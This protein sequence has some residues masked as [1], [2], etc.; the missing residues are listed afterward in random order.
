MRAAYAPYTLNFITPGG[1]SRGVMTT[2]DTYFIKLWDESNPE[3]FGIGECALFKGLSIEDDANYEAKLQELCINI[4]NGEA[5]DLSDHS[6]ILFGFETAILD[7][8]NGGNRICYPT[9]FT[10]GNYH[11]LI[12]GL[13]WMGNKEDMIKR[14][15]EKVNAGFHTIKLKIGAID[16]AQELEMIEYVRTRY[17]EKDLE[18]RLD[19]NGGFSPENALQRIDALSKYKIHSIEQPI[20]AGLWEEMAEICNKSNI[21]IALDEELIGITNPM[22]MMEVLKNIRPHYIIL[23]PSLMGG[24]SGSLEWLKMAAQFQIGGWITSA[25]ESNIGLNALAQWVT[26][27]QPRIPQGLGSGGIF[28]NNISSPLYQ[29]KD[30]LGY[31]P[32][33]KWQIPELNWIST[34]NFK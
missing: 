18:I 14:I 25:L 12:N 17:S 8:S 1:T 2:K 23:K 20:K 27:L 11:I 15:D 29:N 30:F 13:V 6:S 19:A 21:A 22:M 7:F 5:T 16:F 9:A 24:M 10:E 3:I 31:N 33:A 28:S 32:N 26:K 4:E 34:E